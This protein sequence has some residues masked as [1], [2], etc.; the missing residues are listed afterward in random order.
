MRQIFKYPVPVEDD[1]VMVLPVGAQLLN[2]GEQGD[3]PMLWALVDPGAATE[4]RRFIL[5]GTG[6][7]IHHG[8]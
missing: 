4:E 2:F 8:S 5:R 3:T 6:H 1:I 7:P